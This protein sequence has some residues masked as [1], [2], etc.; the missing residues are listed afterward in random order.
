MVK[1]PSRT[2][3][4]ELAG[5]GLIALGLFFLLSLISLKVGVV[6]EN[7]L[8]L[9]GYTSGWVLQY[10]LGLGSYFLVG[11]LFWWGLCLMA[12]KRPVA[13]K[14]K[15]ACLTLLLFSLC[16]LLELIS[17]SFPIFA[18]SLASLVHLSDGHTHLGGVP[19]TYLYYYLPHGNLHHLLS[20]VGTTFLCT[21]LALGS[22]LVMAD[23]R[24]TTILK[25]IVTLIRKI[26]LPS[27]K[28]LVVRFK[29]KEKPAPAPRIVA[30]PPPLPKPQV[31]SPP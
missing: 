28:P 21:G 6:S 30:P 18:A 5:L 3:M 31:V 14:I 19:F 2:L 22:I 27:P 26:R 10:L 8:G 15:I 13:P 11:S 23:V 7:W 20:T 24:I 9:I 17:T 12:G 29:P 4:G 16:L 1:K 25:A